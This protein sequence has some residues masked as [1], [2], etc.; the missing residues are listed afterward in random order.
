MIA[1]ENKCINFVLGKRIASGLIGVRD[2]DLKCPMTS[3]RGF[4]KATNTQDIKKLVVLLK[5]KSG[6]YKKGL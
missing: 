2:K 1:I 6:Y 5:V 4:Q 3:G